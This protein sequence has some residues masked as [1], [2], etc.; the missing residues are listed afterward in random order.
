MGWEGVRNAIAILFL[1]FFLVLLPISFKVALVFLVISVF[2]FG[3]VIIN[4]YEKGVKFRLGKYVGVLEP[5]LHWIIPFIEWVKVVDIRVRTVD[6]PAQEV[7]T[8]DNVP[9]K[10]NGVVYF[11]VED[12][13]K[14]VLNVKDYVFAVAQYAQTALRDVVGKTELDDL[15]SKREKVAEEI[16]KIVDEIMQQWGIDIV[17]I[18][19]QDIFLP[20]ELIRAMARQAEAER[21]KRAA[22]IKSEG[23]IKT[24]ENLKK[25]ADV[26]AKDPKALYLRTLYTLVDISSDPNQ[27]IV[28]LL[29]VEIL[30]FFK[31][32]VE[33]KD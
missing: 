23:E 29:P 4:Q 8:M 27:K 30:D 31:S 7:I 12:P 1:I 20:Q 17:S 16:R 24:A 14:A 33:K 28:V 13:K 6:I 25:A 3:V 32:F 26:L 19:L 9:V 18:N 11:K 5:G 10:V 15:L 21:E 22:I 2:L